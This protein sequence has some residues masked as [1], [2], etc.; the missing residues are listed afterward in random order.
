MR[1]TPEL[2]TSAPQGLN[3]VRDRELVLR[4]LKIPRIENLAVAKDQ[5]SSI[6]LTD[7]DIRR[8]ENL[9]PSH[10][11][12]TLLLA[13]NRIHKIE[14]DLAK[15][16]PN[17]ESLVLTNNAISELGD[18]DPLGNLAKLRYLSLVENPVQGKKHYRSY[19]IARCPSVRV[20]DFRRVKMAERAAATKLFSGTAG[21]DLYATLSAQKAKT[22]D[23]GEGPGGA[24]SREKKEMRAFQAPTPAESAAIRTALASAK[25][26]D[27][28]RQIEAQLRKG[29]VAGVGGAGKGG[30]GG[31]GGP[32]ID[33]VEMDTED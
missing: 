19:V 29:D 28:M 17:L 4:G 33:E 21:K 22:F 18:L 27:E 25:T 3:A 9:P 30:A 14:P 26:L 5:Y 12:T 1:L 7:N 31:G 23:V 11:L 6:D 16:A 15:Y 32:E 20:L 2:V 8:L 13:S 24:E 10:H